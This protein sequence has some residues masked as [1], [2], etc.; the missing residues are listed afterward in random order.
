MQHFVNNLEHYIVNQIIH[1]SWQEFRDDLKH[2]QSLD[3]LLTCH[4]HYL[5]KIIFRSLLSKNAIPVYNLIDKMFSIIATFE[6]RLLSQSWHLHKDSGTVQH[7]LFSQLKDGHCTFHRCSG[8]LFSVLSNL[9]K[10]GY[11]DHLDDLL[12]QVNFNSY[13]NTTAKK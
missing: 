10:R 2:V 4:R 12:L 13:Y 6:S 8:F 3:S 11:Q 7:P 9:V 5:D 1:V